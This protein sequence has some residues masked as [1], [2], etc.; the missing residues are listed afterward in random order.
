MK[1][2]PALWV[3]GALILAACAEP[4][5]NATPPEDPG[6][7]LALRFECNRCHALD[8]APPPALDADCVGC[9]RAIADGSFDAPAEALR[10]WTPHVAPLA[11]AP[12]LRGAGL[13]LRREWIEQFLLHPRDVRPGLVMTMPRLAMS[14]ADAAAL[15][16]WL[17]PSPAPD[18]P[19]DPSLVEVGRALYRAHRCARCHAFDG[20][21]EEAEALDPLAPDLRHARARMPAAAIVAQIRAPR[22]VAPDGAMPALVS[23]DAQA[24]ALAAFVRHAP[25]S[26]PAAAPPA[27]R[28]PLLERPVA[29][30]EVEARVFSRAC[31]HCHSDP[32]FARGDG[33]PGN[34]G[35][36]GFAG[37]GVDLS[38]YEG[39]QSGGLGAD[40]V[41]ASLFAPG[42]SGAPRLVETLL[43]RALEERGGA[44]PGVRGM[45][46]G[47]PALSAEDVQ[48]VET[49][50]AQGRPR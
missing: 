14:E 1:R 13:R 34:R 18:E 21:G 25:L 3:L 32:D 27:P 11:H 45:P 22:S 28:L 39:I 10:D 12:S 50:I 36:F 33:G 40:G 44:V 6:L 23:D 17:A 5:A 19:L 30:A 37:R 47:L 35:G 24:R 38:S 8:G 43:A 16:R 9:H 31:W 20:S 26:A 49:W 46:L 48:L 4:R 41:R 2:G 15:A 42:P 29:F 7:A